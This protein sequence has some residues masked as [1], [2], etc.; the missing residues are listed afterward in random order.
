MKLSTA[1][2]NASN[3]VSDAGNQLVKSADAGVK[4]HAGRISVIV[5]VLTL[6]GIVVQYL[7]ERSHEDFELKMLK[8]QQ[9]NR[10]LSYHYHGSNEV[11]RVIAEERL[12]PTAANQKKE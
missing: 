2:T 1:F 8:A 9:E 6:A 12:Q 7:N 4:E 5:G 10:Q 3:A 11:N